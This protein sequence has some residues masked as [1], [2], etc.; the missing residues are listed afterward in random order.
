MVDSDDFIESEQTQQARAVEVLGAAQNK[1]LQ[2]RQSLAIAYRQVFSAGHTD[3][4]NVDL[5]LNDL[6]AF[7]KMFS[8]IVPS[9]GAEQH[10]PMEVLEGRRQV[11]LRINEHLQLPVTT[12][13]E[14][15]RRA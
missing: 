15:Y 7:G 12:L 11:A 4:A 8:T 5:V 2:A 3:Q 13:Y 9:K 6:M 10:W 14:L 1:E